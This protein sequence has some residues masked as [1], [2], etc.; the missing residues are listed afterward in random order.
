MTAIPPLVCPPDGLPPLGVD[1]GR[2]R[3]RIVSVALGGIFAVLMIRSGQNAYVFALWF[4]AAWLSSIALH[5][6]GHAAAAYA[7]GFRVASIRVGPAYVA[8]HPLGGMRLRFVPAPL[9]GQVFAAPRHWDGNERFRRDVLWFIGGGPAVNLL[10]GAVGLLLSRS[11]SVAWEWSVISLVMGATNLIPAR[12]ST[13]LTTDGEKILRLRRGSANE[14]SLMALRMMLAVFPPR[15]WDPRLVAVAAAESESRGSD[16]I[17]ATLLLY[18]HTHDTG[19]IAG[20]AALLQ[21]LID[22]ACG[23]ARWPRTTIP[24]EVASEAAAFEARWRRDLVA[25]RAWL[26]RAPFKKRRAAKLLAKL[27]RLAASNSSSD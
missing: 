7:R 5:E 8:P 3:Q 14:I 1:R 26:T 22:Y 6:V 25:A 2:N 24:L 9:G 20:A 15:E 12:H 11:W 17:D 4:I 23:T 10:A 27:E 16:A 21:R 18:Y 19:D 13:G